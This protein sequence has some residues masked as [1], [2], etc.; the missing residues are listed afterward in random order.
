[1]MAEYGAAAGFSS[2]LTQGMGTMNN[3]QQ[4]RQQQQ[5][6]QQDAE[7]RRQTLEITRQQ[8]GQKGLEETNRKYEANLKSLSDAID[9]APDSGR[10]G[11]ILQSLEKTGALKGLD[12]MAQ[13]VQ[14][15][16]SAKDILMSRVMAKRSEEEQLAMKGA[17]AGVTAEASAKANAKYRAPEADQY[18]AVPTGSG[19]MLLDKRSG[20]A[21]MLGTGPDGS[22]TQIG[23][24][25][26]PVGGPGG[27]PT[28][29]S[30]D[31]AQQAL[32]SAQSPKPLMPPSI[33]AQ[34]Q[35]A[36]VTAQKEAELMVEKKA[37]FPKAQAALASLNQQQTVVEDAL[38]KAIKNV[39]PW[40]AGVGAW[41]SALPATQAKA[42]RS[43]LNTI[44]ANLG[45]D[46]LQQMRDNSPTGGALG[47]VVVQEILFLQSSVK[48]LDQELKP[49]E[50]K[51]KLEFIQSNLKE[52]KSLREQAF[53]SD[54][55]G[56]AS[57]D[58][59]KP[60]QDGW[61]SL[62]NGIRVRVKK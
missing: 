34:A 39:S 62:P 21:V 6:Q 17:E 23:Q 54:Y 20:M 9:N 56:V 5:A 41:A 3:I 44:K 10:A 27:Q 7:L 58:A 35:G 60:D 24:P 42:L 55:A 12:D 46:K 40:S 11:A 26:R 59:A 1:M 14:S 2:G 13:V 38:D 45:F 57:K 50:L 36:V 29:V 51:D 33:D 8:L 28:A 19:T 31:S 15:P 49:S 25:F 43:D 32:P 61:R 53:Q 48:E 47:S 4:L 37:K 18:Y 22:P 16:A 30:T 52:L